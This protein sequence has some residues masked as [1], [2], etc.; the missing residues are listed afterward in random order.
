MNQAPTQRGHP[1]I[2]LRDV[3]SQ[4]V[5]ATSALPSPISGDS[6]FDR[7]GDDH[8][9]LWGGPDFSTGP[10]RAKKPYV[11]RRS[12]SADDTFLR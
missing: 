6:P 5:S 7:H 8:Y 10:R 11:C 3:A 12:L 9:S 4:I 2:P 1:A